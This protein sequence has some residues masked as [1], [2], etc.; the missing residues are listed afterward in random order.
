MLKQASQLL[1]AYKLLIEYSIRIIVLKDGPV[2][3]YVA[4]VSQEAYYVFL[5]SS[6]EKHTVFFQE[7]SKA[8][9]SKNI[10]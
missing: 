10:R 5:I 6:P 3:P 1:F 4:Q 8:V 2:V 9:S 7:K